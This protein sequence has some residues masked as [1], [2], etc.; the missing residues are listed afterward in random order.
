MKEVCLFIG[1]VQKNNGQYLNVVK[2]LMEHL[3]IHKQDYRKLSHIQYPYE[4]IDIKDLN[5]VK[6]QGGLYYTAMCELELEGKTHHHRLSVSCRVMEKLFR[7]E[8]IERIK[9]KI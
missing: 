2:M 9:T 5:Y 3:N 6:N 8:K 7:R 1:S 4:V